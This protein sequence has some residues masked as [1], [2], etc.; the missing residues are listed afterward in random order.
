MLHKVSEYQL[1]KSGSVASLNIKIN[2]AINEGWVPSGPPVVEDKQIY[3][4]MVKFS[5]EEI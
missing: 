3:Q 5:S 1:I 4:A 2:D